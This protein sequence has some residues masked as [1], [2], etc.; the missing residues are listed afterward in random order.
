MKKLYKKIAA[1]LESVP[2]DK[3]IHYNVCLVVA[4]AIMRVLPLPTWQRYVIAVSVTILIGVAKEVYD[5]FDY[6]L[7]DCKDL[8]ADCVGAVTGATL[9]I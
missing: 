6:G 1:L 5:Y 4:C 3:Y 2:S 8:L 9:G 7:F